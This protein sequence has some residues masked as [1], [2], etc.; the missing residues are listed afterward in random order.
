MTS[1]P[2]LAALAVV[3]HD[4]KLLLVRRRNEPDAGLWGY[5]GGKVD[6][7]ETVLCAAAR[8]LLEE[9]T[10]IGTPLDCLM[11]LDVIQ[12]TP[13]GDVDHHFHL[14]AVLCAFRA[15][16]PAAR[17]DVSEAVWF[18]VATVLNGEIP[19]SRD[20]DTVLKAALQRMDT[21]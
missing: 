15:G 5:P 21:G 16:Q 19:M 7:G 17:D 13:D 1:W 12:R 14:V 2:K 6:P 4:G 3:P 18:D 8:E 9:T 11:N 10:L 20:V